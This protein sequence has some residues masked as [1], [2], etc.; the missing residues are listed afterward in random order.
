MNEPDRIRAILKEAR[1]IAVVGCSP[2]PAR[3]SNSIARYLLSQGYRVVPINPGHAAIL[4]RDC[5]PSLD[6]VPA[7]IDLDVVDVFRE[8]SHVAA[9]VEPSLRRGVR[10]FWMQEG[11]IDRESARRLEEA[12]I[13][14]AMDLCILKEHRRYAPF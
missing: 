8:S 1:S 14:V 9:L 6:A 10:F 5:Y 12:G 4:G 3:P 13:G 11:V 7:E 2:N